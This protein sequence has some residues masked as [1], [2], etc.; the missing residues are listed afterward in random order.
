[1]TT[2]LGEEFETGQKISSH[3]LKSRALQTIC[4]A[5]VSHL[6][7]FPVYVRW[8]HKYDGLFLFLKVE[9]TSFEAF[10]INLKTC[11]MVCVERGLSTQ[12]CKNGIQVMDKAVNANIVS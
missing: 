3:V 2:L 4:S 6:A 11:V 10:D 7:Q 9:H 8:A 5:D 12:E 1:M